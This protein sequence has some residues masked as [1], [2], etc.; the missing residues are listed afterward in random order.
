MVLASAI[1]FSACGSSAPPPMPFSSIEVPSAAGSDMVTSF[2]SVLPWPVQGS[3]VSDGAYRGYKVEGPDY[4]GIFKRKF[5]LT[6]LNDFYTSKLT[7]AGWDG[8]EGNHVLEREARSL[9]DGAALGQ[10]Q[11][12]HL[13]GD[14][15]KPQPI[16]HLSIGDLPA[17]EIGSATRQN[18]PFIE[19]VGAGVSVAE[20]GS[21]SSDDG[22]S[23][24]SHPK[25]LDMPDSASLWRHR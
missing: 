5:S 18:W 23:Y 20:R 2:V 1:T 15:P 13:R 22:G 10:R 19:G 3:V 12:G 17:D 8:C 25:D 16:H 24:A 7:P 4:Y 14:L 21:R 9:R 11:P 6:E